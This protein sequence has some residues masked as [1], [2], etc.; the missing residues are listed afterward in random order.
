MQKTAIKEILAEKGVN[1][2][3]AELEIFKRE[4]DQTKRFVG[5][6]K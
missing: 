3:G 5:A 2:Q 4:C 1:F 6:L